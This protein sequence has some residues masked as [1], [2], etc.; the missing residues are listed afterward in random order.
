MER[1]LARR[2]TIVTAVLALLASMSVAISGEAEPAVAAAPPPA[3]KLEAARRAVTVQTFDGSAFLDLGIYAVAGDRPFEVRAYR[4]AYSQPISAWRVM[5][6]AD[7]PLPTGLVQD[8]DGLSKFFSLSIKNA[9]QK[10]VLSTTVGFCPNGSD[11]DT[12][13]RRPDAPAT[14][15]YPD[16]CF[17]NPYSTG[18]VWG[19]QR[20]YA[21]P[22]LEGVDTPLTPG[23]YTATL[24]VRSAYRSALQ[25]RAADGTATVQ[26]KVVKGSDD[27]DAMASET[28]KSTARHPAAVRPVGG[29]AKP[30]GP[31]PDLRSLPAW[32][33]AV[34]HGRYLDFSATV[35]NAGPSPLVVDGFRQAN[36]ENRMDAYQYFFDAKNK[37]VG[38]AGVGTMEWDPRPGHEHWHFSDFA[39]Y[40]LLDRHKKLVVRSQKEAFCL[41]NTDAID[42]TVPNANWRPD[43]TDLHTACGSD[44][45]IA[46]RE[47]LETGSGDTYVQS[48]PGQSFDLKGLKNGVYYVE[49]R[50]NP[51]KRLY[52]AFTTNNVAYRKV[53]VSG[54][55]GHR[56]V[57]VQKVGVVV[58]P[59]P[60]L[61]NPVDQ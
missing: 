5:P 57:K 20:G 9:K 24:S 4:T 30:E 22:A 21:T 7:A 15:P 13:R 14:S 41:A 40:R 23:T 38:Y 43:N 50:A 59:P 45:S 33:I 61:E 39:T 36:N 51:D 25:I 37:Q 19:I 8:F 47:V 2:A 60:E 12:V 11:F 52:E 10:S 54:K 55:A 58:E 26:V 34:E 31:L 29:A 46:V 18:A 6:A 16:G 1:T 42:Y 17:G 48:L 27:E 28:V 35:W 32:G 49:V 44:T 56:K 3:F 53:K